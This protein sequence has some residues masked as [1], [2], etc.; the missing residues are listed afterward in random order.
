MAG[1]REIEEEVIRTLRTLM[2]RGTVIGPDHRLIAD[3]HLA[4][5]DATAMAIELGK[6]Y[7]VKMPTKEWQ[8]VL[9]VRD[10][11]NLLAR[12]AT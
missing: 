10:V 9:T 5:D 2:P 8:T 3:L 7:R 4:S 11:I 6:K 1:V 12:Y